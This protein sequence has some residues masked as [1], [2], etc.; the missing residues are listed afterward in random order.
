MIRVGKEESGISAF[1][2]VYDKL[3]ANQYKAQTRQILELAQWKVCGW[4]NQWQIIMLIFT[5]IQN[6]PAKSW[7]DSFVAVNLH[8]HHHLYFS[9]WIKKI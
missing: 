1:N 7:T 5:A 6:I 9:G 2:Q 3:Q 8:P 4:I